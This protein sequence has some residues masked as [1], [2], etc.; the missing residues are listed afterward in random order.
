MTVSLEDRIAK[1][2]KFRYAALGFINAQ[3]TVITD[4]WCNFVKK[5]DVDPIAT[6]ERLKKQW[7]LTSLSCSPSQTPPEPANLKQMLVATPIWT[8]S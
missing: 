8:G 6:V 5:S 1:L 4:L 7:L 3:N 2:E